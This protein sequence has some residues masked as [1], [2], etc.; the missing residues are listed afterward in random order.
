VSSLEEAGGV[1]GAGLEGAVAALLAGEAVV[2]P[3]DTVY[4]VATATAVPGSTATLFRLKRRPVDV[5]LPVLCADEDQARALA[6]ALPAA[7]SALMAACWPGPLT[8]V[9]PRRSGLDLDLGG[10][11]DE[12]IGLR[13]PDA[14]IV[15]AIA[16][17]VGPLACTSANRHGHPTPAT[18]AEAAAALGPGVGAV[19][20]GGRCEGL[21]STV[22]GWVGSELRVLRHG[23]LTVDDLAAVLHPR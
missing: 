18:A 19:V 23:S 15:R 16:G 1:A 6:G 7:A 12:T 4:G 22:V 14:P 9:V 21:P 17:R 20:D 11:D 2:V 10:P 5:A 3:T 13:V 8:L